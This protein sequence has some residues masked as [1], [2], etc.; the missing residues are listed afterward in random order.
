MANKLM[1][2]WSPIPGLVYEICDE[3]SRNR[4]KKIEDRESSYFTS[5]NI[6]TTLKISGG[7]ADAKAVGDALTQKL[8]LDGNLPMMGSLNMNTYGILNI[9]EPTIDKD[10]TT[11]KYVDTLVKDT[12][13]EIEK[14]YD[15]KNDTL[16]QKTYTN[17][18]QIGCTTD[19]TP[20]E[21]I[22]AIPSGSI[23]I[24]M[25]E[26]LT[27]GAWNFP[28]SVTG[29]YL[30]QIIKS[31]ITTET[32]VE[33]EMIATTIERVKTILLGK[34]IQDGD[35]HAVTDENGIPIGNWFKTPRIIP[36]T[37][38]LAVAD[39]TDNTQSVGV[40]GVVADS[41]KCQVLVNPAL[42]S[43]EDFSLSYVRCT[44][45]GENQLTFTCD[46]VPPIDLVVNILA[47]V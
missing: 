20:T 27:N 3:E 25:T 24:C 8:S 22:N 21:I 18:I 16:N 10:V 35:Y 30:L 40:Y 42:D 46:K 34:S 7:L 44:A 13:E 1:K 41:S 4:I 33:G 39:W 12:K 5:E 28:T 38:T 36:A 6:D 2:T 9:K 15:T 26:E 14:K 23:F 29:G 32:E 31:S 45:Q 19:S 17:P 11:K 37:I 47:F 43:A